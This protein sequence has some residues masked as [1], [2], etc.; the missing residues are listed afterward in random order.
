[1]HMSLYSRY[2]TSKELMENFLEDYKSF[3]KQDSKIFIKKCRAK[4]LARLFLIITTAI[5]NQDLNL[6][7]LVL[8]I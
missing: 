4:N 7:M 8:E 2:A 5:I 3:S 6:V 1:M